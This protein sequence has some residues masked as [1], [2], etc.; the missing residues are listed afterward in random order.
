MIMRTAVIAAALL[1]L[2]AGAEACSILP[3]IPPPALDPLPGET[4]EEFSARLKLHLDGFQALQQ[5]NAQRTEADRQAALWEASAAVAVVEVKALTRDIPTDT[6]MGKGNRVDL[7]VAGWLK[8]PA[9]GAKK[10]S[11][12]T[13]SM[14]QTSFTSCGPMPMWDVFRGEPGDRFVVFFDAG[15]ITHETAREA[16]ATA[17]VV[18]PAVVQALAA[19]VR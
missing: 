3:P 7:K 6:P 19:R 17:S 10:G 8:G 9:P 11:P 2:H 4:Q 15:G 16:M 12:K 14:R 13:L 5:M 1:F 18:A